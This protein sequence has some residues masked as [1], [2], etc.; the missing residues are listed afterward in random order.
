LAHSLAALMVERL[1]AT[2]KAMSAP[3]ATRAQAR[4]DLVGQIAERI[5]LFLSELRS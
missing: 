1:R 2:D 3:S 5:K 4:T